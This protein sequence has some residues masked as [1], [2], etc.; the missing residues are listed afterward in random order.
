ME[1]NG[2]M[3]EV[4]NLQMYFL[5]TKGFLKR[6]VAELRAVDGVS[7]SIAKGETLGLVGESGCGKTTVGRCVARLYQPTSGDIIFE[8]E[9]ISKLRERQL[10]RVRRSI[11]LIFQDPYSSLDPRQSAGSAVGEPLRIHQLSKGRSDH[12]QRVEELFHLV[13]L[14]P[15]MGNR[16]PHEFS[17][18]QRQRLGI[19]R[20]LASD[21]S[22]II[23]DEPISAL[24]VS[25]QAQIINL[26]E[27]L[28]ESKKGLS[29]L[30]IAHDLAVVKHISHR[31][32]VM[33]LG[34]M[35]EVTSPVDLYE[36]P[37]HPYTKALL[38]A[39]PV[40]DPCVEERRKR[41][42]LKGEVPSLLSPPSGCVFHSRCP[43]A[44]S[45]CSSVAPALKDLGKGHAVSCIRV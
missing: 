43:E 3:L 42:I 25:T 34:H 6:K 15:S 36:N 44:I 16:F 28:R 22:L 10:R 11:A 5:V 32:A 38:S 41:I 19:A 30:F 1:A 7:F 37:L 24:D 39:V 20:A 2:A 18:G 14:D 23:C 27:E 8:G 45:E 33:Y 35:V 4:N 31:I 26:L 12:R 40:P 13:G 29:Y 9:N 17:G 21:P